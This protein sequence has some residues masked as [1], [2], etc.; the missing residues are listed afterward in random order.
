MSAKPLNPKD[1]KDWLFTEQQKEKVVEYVNN[2]LK[3]PKLNQENKIE[4]S[5]PLFCVN[6]DVCS[7]HRDI[8]VDFLIQTYKEWNVTF[9][10]NKATICFT[11][12]EPYEFK[13][14]R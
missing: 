1:I 8:L 14:K 11:S 4:V 3:F 12:P 5:I 9:L 7:V 2:R 6:D 10:T 13:N